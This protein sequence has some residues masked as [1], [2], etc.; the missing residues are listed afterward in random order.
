[1]QPSDNTE[2]KS[3]IRLRGKAGRPRWEPPDFDEVEEAARTG[4]S[5]QFI[6]DGLG[7]SLAT[8]NRKRK[9]FEKFEQAIRRGR[10]RGVLETARMIDKAI[11]AGDTHA[12]V[13]RM[14]YVGGWSEKSAVEVSGPDGGPIEVKAAVSASVVADSELKALLEKYADIART[15]TDSAVNARDVAGLGTGEDANAV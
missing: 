6:A 8:L 15:A 9:D 14:R 2:E 5:Y 3:E 10:A 4:V 1:M 12:A 13:S 11:K 7:I